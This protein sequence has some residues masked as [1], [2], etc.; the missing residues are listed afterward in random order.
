[1][2]GGELAEDKEER[3]EAGEVEKERGVMAEAGE[4]EKQTF[5]CSDC[6]KKYAFI[7]KLQNHQAWG[8]KKKKEVE[9]VE[10]DFARRPL[11]SNV[12]CVK[13]KGE[14]HVD[15]ES[16]GAKPSKVDFLKHIIHYLSNSFRS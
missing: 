16:V 5:Q 8:C 14:D 7:H 10:I 2:E 13:S 15:A 11:S 9:K 12:F 6:E 4:V 1:M 3:A